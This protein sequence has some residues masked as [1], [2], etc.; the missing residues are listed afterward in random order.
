MFFFIRELLPAIV[1][2]QQAI[3]QNSKYFGT[4]NTCTFS[5]QKTWQTWL[6]LYHPLPA[7]HH[8]GPNLP[9]AKQASRQSLPPGHAVHRA[10]APR[11]IVGHCRQPC[12]WEWWCSCAGGECMGDVLVQVKNEE[13]AYLIPMFTLGVC[14]ELAKSQVQTLHV[15]SMDYPHVSM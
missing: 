11:G 15:M 5:R 13:S 3:P 8:Q 4:Y 2:I 10:A 12:R 6:Y 9:F 14:Q 7:I 1:A